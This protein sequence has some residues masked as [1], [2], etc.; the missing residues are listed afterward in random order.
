MRS[1]ALRTRLKGIAAHC[2]NWRKC[3][4]KISAGENGST[5]RCAARRKNERLDVWGNAP[6]IY[7]QVTCWFSAV[8]GHQVINV[9]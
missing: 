5:R 8:L 2:W 6:H 1:T 9:S 7:S 3:L 4:R